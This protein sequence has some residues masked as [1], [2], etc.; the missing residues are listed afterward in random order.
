MSAFTVNATPVSFQNAGGQKRAVITATGPTSYDTNGSVID[1]ATTGL[2]ATPHGFVAVHGVTLVAVPV[3]GSDIYNA[4]YVHAA[5]YAPAT[6]TVKVR[7]LTAA[8]DAEI[9]NATNLSTVTFVFEVIG[10]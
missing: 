1:L 10:T 5:S 6:G 3:H 9:A 4:R 8:S 2:L 7:D